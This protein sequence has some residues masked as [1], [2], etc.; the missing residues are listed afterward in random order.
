MYSADEREFLELWVIATFITQNPEI[1]KSV[2]IRM[3]IIF[4]ALTEPNAFSIYQ[5]YKTPYKL[6]AYKY[7]GVNC[8]DK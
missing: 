5:Y 6:S 3:Q 1:K 2:K 7:A 8:I 4:S